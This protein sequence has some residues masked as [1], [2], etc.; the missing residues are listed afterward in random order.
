MTAGSELA[1][2]QGKA[3]LVESIPM[4]LENLRVTEGV[5]Y[6]GEVLKRLTDSAQES[7]DLTAM[8]WALTPN[9]EGQDDKGFT[10]DELLEKYGASEGQALFAA[11][12]AAARRGV[13]IRIIE[14][15]GFDPSSDESRMLKDAF[16]EQVKIHRINM[17]NWYGS[18]IMQQKFWIFD[19]R[20]IYLGSANMDWKSLTQVKEIG[21]AV[22]GSPDVARELG[23]YYDTW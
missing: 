16:P 12:K 18:G 17:E 2:T 1:T 3:Y 11:L 8:Y 13:R 19:Q 6:T 23:R 14:S 22:E 15:P 10:V 21:I 4:G 7:I 9:P 5:G 20:G